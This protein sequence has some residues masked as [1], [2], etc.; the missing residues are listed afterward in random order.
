MASVAELRRLRNLHGAR[1]NLGAIHTA[2][3]SLVMAKRDGR[4]ERAF[5][6]ACAAMNIRAESASLHYDPRD[7]A[8]HAPR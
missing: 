6:A 2:A 1:A 8:G 7:V 3:L 4:R 5:V